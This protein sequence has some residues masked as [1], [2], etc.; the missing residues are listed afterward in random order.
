MKN[1][2]RWIVLIPASVVIFSVAFFVSSLLT[3]DDLTSSVRQIGF[4]LPMILYYGIANGLATF[5][6]IFLCYYICPKNNIGRIVGAVASVL[7]NVF[8]WSYILSKIAEGTPTWA[9]IIIIVSVLIS[10]GVG[11]LGGFTTNMD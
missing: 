1:A 9:Y 7:I 4:G 6:T 2:I 3:G 5:I 8:I 10:L 11:I